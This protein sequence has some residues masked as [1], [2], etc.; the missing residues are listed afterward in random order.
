MTQL[1]DRFKPDNIP[2]PMIRARLYNDIRRGR[3]RGDSGSWNERV[4][5]P[6]ER[7]LPELIAFRE[8]GDHRLKWVVLAAASMDDYRLPLESGET[9]RLPSI[10]WL[11]DRFRHYERMSEV[12]VT[13][14]PVLARA[15]ET[16][17][18]ASE[19]T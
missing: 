13:P 19:S 3:P 14:P 11:R 18:A 6:G 5:A 12:D 8:Y 16:G 1:S 10:E 9:L 15:S 17:A 2:D 4:I 7:L